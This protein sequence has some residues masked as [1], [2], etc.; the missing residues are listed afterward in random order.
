MSGIRSQIAIVG[1]PNVGKSTLF[2]IMTG[3]R[4]ALVQNQPGVTRDILIEEAEIWGKECDFV[5]TGGITEAKDL[6][7]VLVR[8]QVTSYL[9]TVDFVVFVVDGRLGMVPEDRDV[10]RII[11][12]S[13][14]KF[15]VIANK[16]DSSEKQ[17]IQTAEFYEF[18]VEV[19][20]A[21][22]EQ[23]RGLARLMEVLYE[24]L[25]D[26]KEL[27]LYYRRIAIVGKPNVGKSS[28]VNHLMGFKRVLVSDQPGTTLDSVEADFE[29]ENKTYSLIDTAGLRR[30]ARREDDLEIL[31]AIKSQDSIRRAH[32]IFLLVDVTEGPTDQDAKV[33][34]ACIDA[35]KTVILVANK[36]DLGQPEMRL[37]FREKMD[38]TFHFHNDL[39]LAFISAKTGVGLPDL[40]RKVEQLLFKLEK[41]ISTSDLNDFFF[42]TIRKAPAPVYGNT[43]VKFY[44]LTQ[45]RQEP[46]SFLCFANHPEG[47]DT[48]YRRFLVKHIKVRFGLEGVP[49]RLFVM[50]SRRSDPS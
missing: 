4:K 15:V 14:K 17:D 8:D 38:R 29:Y 5:D 7:S 22:F 37:Q 6:I 9:K 40:F 11:K 33:L 26:T 12:E 41:Q 34:E 47:V 35:G 43:N 23:R 30:S 50:K 48:S 13:G 44:Y 10:F 20:P 1:R 46:P 3:T 32:I 16:I 2:N 18:G 27:Q 36:I 39:E 24:V 49:V 42:E 28:L 25:P 21:S 45:T 19:I 31:S